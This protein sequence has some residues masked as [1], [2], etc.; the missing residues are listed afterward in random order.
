MYS[1]QIIGNLDRKIANLE[2]LKD[3][4]QR[5]RNEFNQQIDGLRLA[6]EAEFNSVKKA[7]ITDFKNVSDKVNDLVILQGEC[8]NII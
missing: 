7:E 1:F 6:T 5:D 2:K 8:L 3:I 4:I